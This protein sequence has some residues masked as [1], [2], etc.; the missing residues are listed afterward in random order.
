MKR[1]VL[2]AAALAAFSVSAPAQETVVKVGTARAISVGATLYAIEKGYFKEAGVKLDMDYINSSADVMAMV[3][4][5]QYHIVEGGV[6]AG[7][8]NAVAKDLPLRLIADRTSSPIYHNIMLRPELKDTVKQI[9]DLKGRT[10]A[11]NGPGSISTYEIGKVLEAGGLSLKD[12]EIKIIPF[13]Q[14]GIALKNGAVDAALLIPP[15]SYQAANEGLAVM[16]IDPDDY[17]KPQ[18]VSLAV[19]IINTDW[20]AKNQQAVK[21]YYVAYLKG[22]RAYCQAVHGG[23]PRK[24]IIDLLVRDKIEPRRETLE[25]LPWQSRD[26]NGKINVASVLDVQDFYFNGKFIGQK[27]PIEKIVDS[28]YVDEAAKK[29]GPFVVENKASTVKGCR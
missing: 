24:E 28:S 22:V 11:S 15:F 5:G 2:A 25:T 19:N 20:A 8:F 29:L 9:K 1:I 6:S 26:V 21:N 14:M 13:T 16:F 10:I 27:L 18:P 12:V 17:Q 3:A 7:F 23:S 4:Q